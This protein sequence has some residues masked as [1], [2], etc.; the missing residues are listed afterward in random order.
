MKSLNY[1]FVNKI[2]LENQYLEPAFSEDGGLCSLL[3]RQYKPHSVIYFWLKITP[4][5]LI[6]SKEEKQ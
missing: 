5:N 4:L 6:G 3:L 1:H 2:F